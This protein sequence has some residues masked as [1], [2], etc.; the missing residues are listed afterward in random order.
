MN[1]GPFPE[2]Y[3]PLESAVKNTFS[4]KQV[5]PV[6]TRWDEKAKEKTC[7]PIIAE[8][9]IAAT[10]GSEDIKDFPIICSTYRVTEHWQTGQMT[11]WLPW[12]DE[13]VPNQFVEMSEEFAKEKGITFGDKVRCHLSQQCRR[14]CGICH[15]HE[16]SETLCHRR[17]RPITWWASP[18]TSGIRAW[19]PAAMP[20]TSPRS[21]EIR[22]P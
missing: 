14:H 16:T 9:C 20:T 18:G 10:Y 12:L 11:R 5:S 2:H 13:M 15:D 17:E 8:G 7:N 3:E 4:S 1:D 21:S 22:T 19:S 6:I